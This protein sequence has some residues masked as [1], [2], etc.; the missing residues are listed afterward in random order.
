MRVGRA[1]IARYRDG[2]ALEGP[3][4]EFAKAVGLLTKDTLAD[5][6]NSF[7]RDGINAWRPL[8]EG[9]PAYMWLISETNTRAA[10]V[11]AGMHYARLN[12]AATARGVAMHPWS[13]TLQEYPEMAEFY[14]EAERLTATREG[15]TL[16][17]LVRVGYGPSIAPAPRRGLPE[18]LSA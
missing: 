1:E 8:A 9:A 4:I 12:L 6:S 18:H 15:E 3:M 13:Q 5:T 17:M 14:A 2:I 10:Q 11:V 16:Q 7:T